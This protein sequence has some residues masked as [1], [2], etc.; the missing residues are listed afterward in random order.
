M[1]STKIVILQNGAV[2]QFVDIPAT[3]AYQL[4]A[5]HKRLHKEIVKLTA[6]NVPTLPKAIAECEALEITD[7]SQN[8]VTSLDYINELEKTWAAIEEKSY[9]IISLLTEIRALQAQLEQWYEDE[10]ES[11]F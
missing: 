1:A 5:L 3:H 8:T 2:I 9:P 11:G 6:A 10:A 4:T 7:P